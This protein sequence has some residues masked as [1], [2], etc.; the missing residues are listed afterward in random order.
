M[1]LDHIGS[2]GSE[3]LAPRAGSIAYLEPNIHALI[4]PSNATR[5]MAVFINII[6]ID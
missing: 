4:F 2:Y 1:Q 5:S 6:H 3:S